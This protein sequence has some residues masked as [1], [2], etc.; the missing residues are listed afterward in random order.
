MSGRFKTIQHHLRQ[1]EGYHV[2]HFIGHGGFDRNTDE[3]VLVLEDKQKLGVPAGASRIRVLLQ[4]HW[5]LRLAVLNSCE[6]ARNSLTDPFAGVAA[7]LIRQG[8]P[9]VTAMQFEISD[10]AAITFADEFYTVLTEGLPADA[11]MAEARKGIYGDMLNDVEW[12]TPVLYTSSKDGILFRFPE[13]PEVE[14]KGHQAEHVIEEVEEEPPNEEILEEP[15]PEPERH[16]A[17]PVI[18]V[19]EEEEKPAENKRDAPPGRLTNSLSMEFVYIHPGTF[20]MGSPEDEPGRYD[21]ESLHEVTLIRGFYMQVTVG[22]WRAFAQEAGFKTQAETEGGAY[23]WTGSG[24]E[25]NKKYFWDNPGFSQDDSHPVTCVSWNDVRAFAEW[26]SQKENAEKYRLPTEAEWEYS[27]RAGSSTRYC[28]GDD[29]DQLSEYAWYEK[30]SERKTHPVGEKKF[31]AW[32]LYDMHGN[33]W[34]WSQDWY[35]DYPTDSVTDPTGPRTGS[36][37]VYRGGSWSD[38]AGYCRSA[39]RCYDSPGFRR[40]DLGFRLALSPGQQ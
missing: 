12:G 13:E 18:E 25:K 7:T 38:S 4:D 19:I 39:N 26:I 36:D 22:Q 1:A 10:K 6:G 30:N 24:W 2:F 8:I 27:C 32:G 20:M 31:N 17:E 40:Y 11:A 34:E 21:R 3:G 23:G 33:V 37:R 15:E 35:G 16:H 14:M 28:F 29:E 9:A 5:S